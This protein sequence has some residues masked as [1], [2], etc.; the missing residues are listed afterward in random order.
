[1]KEGIEMSHLNEVLT[2]ADLIKYLNIGTIQAM[3]IRRYFYQKYSGEDMTALNLLNVEHLRH[4]EIEL[5]ELYCLTHSEIKGIEPSL[6]AFEISGSLP[7]PLPGEL[8]EVDVCRKL[9]NDAKYRLKIYGIYAS[10]ILPFLNTVNKHSAEDATALSLLNSSHLQQ[11]EK[12]LSE[13][14]HLNSSEIAELEPMLQDWENLGLTSASL[15]RGLSEVDIYR[16]LVNDVEYR[17]KI[18]DIYESEIAPFL[19]A[20]N[21]NSDS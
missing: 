5:N 17:L 13:L 3:V 16:R 11:P 21:K 12:A 14:Y 6:Q 15:P 8:S 10:E 19:K 7:L 4:P 20:V 18:C 1:M 2:C 9:V